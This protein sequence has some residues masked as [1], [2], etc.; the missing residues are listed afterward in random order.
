MVKQIAWI[1][2]VLMLFAGCVHSTTGDTPPAPPMVETATATDPCRS[3][4]SQTELT[5]CW[6]QAAETGEAGL[7]DALSKTEAA[8]RGAGEAEVV[9]LLA[10]TQKQWE[11]YRNLQCELHRKRF[12]GGT[13]EGMADAICRYRMAMDRSREL[14]SV[15]EEWSER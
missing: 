8:L 7:R 1:A 11:Q 5:V 9:A 13:G 3:A 2:S 6:G 12:R 4:Q 10:A 14:R 15:E